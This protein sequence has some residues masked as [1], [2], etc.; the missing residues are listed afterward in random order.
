MIIAITGGIGSGKSV[1]S[2]LLRVEGH[3][4]FDTDL[5]ARLLMEHSPVIRDGLIARFGAEVYA[6]GRLN[7][8]FL[9][10]AIFGDDQ[11]LRDVNA[12]VHPE[13][14]RA[15]RA[16]YERQPGGIA[17]FESAILF[18]SGFEGEA[19]AV[20]SV[21]APEAVRIARAVQR[22]GASPEQVRS[23]MAAQLPQADKDA[24]ADVVILNDDRLPLIPQVAAALEKAILH[25]SRLSD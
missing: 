12:L 7:R 23:R 4:V 2:R 8:P 3:P 10:R 15:L 11:A 9:A 19:D 1:V 25:A 18:E 20:W 13:V 22:D 21:S 5:E 14:K 17:F 24:R 16:W 6:E